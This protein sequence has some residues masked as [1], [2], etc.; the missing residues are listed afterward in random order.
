M[1]LY[2][3]NY[4]YKHIFNIYHIWER[5]IKKSFAKL[6]K[7]LEITNT[8]KIS[9][10]GVYSLDGTWTHLEPAITTVRRWLDW[11]CSGRCRNRCLLQRPRSLCVCVHACVRLHA[12]AF[13]RRD[14]TYEGELGINEANGTEGMEFP[15]SL[16]ST[17]AN[18]QPPHH[19]ITR[20]SHLRRRRDVVRRSWYT[21]NE[22]AV[23]SPFRNL[24]NRLS[25][26]NSNFLT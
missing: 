26:P 13:T 1:Y 24:I 6:K 22:L 4:R 19:R 16:F 11:L 15:T 10:K 3:S 12:F 2:Y 14:C 18:F 7:L 25:R 8:T 5:S 9:A 23:L 17:M 21:R 20:T